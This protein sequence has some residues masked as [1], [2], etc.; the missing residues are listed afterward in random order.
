[1]HKMLLK[2]ATQEEGEGSPCSVVVDHIAIGLDAEA[3][4]VTFANGATIHADLVIGADGIRVSPRIL[5][6]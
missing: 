3:G 5:A 4:T 1:M 6:S 2:T